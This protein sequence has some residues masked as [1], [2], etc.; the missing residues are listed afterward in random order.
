MTAYKMENKYFIKADLV[1]DTAFHIGSGE[2]GDEISD[3]KILKDV[4]NKPILPGSSLKGKFRSDSE[5][6][7]H[8]LDMKAC[9]LDT[10]LSGVRC[11][12][13]VDD[14]EY[15]QMT[16]NLSDAKSKL[17]FIDENVC[18]I[19]KL[20]GSKIHASR[21]FFSDGKL[22]KS[23]Q[24][25]VYIRDGVVIDRDLEKA[26]DGLKYNF[27]VAPEDTKYQI[28]IEIENPETNEL[29]LIR[30]ILSM[31]QDNFK[32]GGYSSRGLGHARLENIDIRLLEFGK[33]SQSFLN[34]LENKE[35]N[36]IDLVKLGA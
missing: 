12:N 19:C 2:A 13:G 36:K 26:V 23:W 1:F 7:A 34:F 3:S 27:E 20:F 33:N 9:M 6:I 22:D 16:R 14:R 5:K 15:K 24:D 28:K 21:I 35:L 10:S 18:D 8:A 30:A 32:I 11:A 17:D 31:W 29:K 4:F 25:I